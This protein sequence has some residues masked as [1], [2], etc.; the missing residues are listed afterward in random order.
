M[1]C[2]YHRMGVSGRGSAW[3]G[4]ESEERERERGMWS[5]PLGILYAHTD[6]DIRMCSFGDDDVA[7]ERW[8][9][10]SDDASHGEQR[11]N[12]FADESKKLRVKETRRLG[13]GRMWRGDVVNGWQAWRWAL[14]DEVERDKGR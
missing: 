4:A 3:M 9:Y 8:K 7:I 6:D 10:R 12:E 13:T 5:R 2:W 1:D 11:M 14:G